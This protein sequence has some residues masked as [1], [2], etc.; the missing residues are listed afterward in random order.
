MWIRLMIA[1]SSMHIKSPDS[2]AEWTLLNGLTIH[3]YNSL[4]YQD[5]FLKLALRHH[6]VLLTRFCV[7]YMFKPKAVVA[8]VCF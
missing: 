7:I 3:L 4:F 8:Q 6:T 1:F 5:K 2:A